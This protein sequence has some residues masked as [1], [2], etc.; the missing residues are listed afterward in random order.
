MRTQWKVLAGA[1]AC[2]L[3]TTAILSSGNVA[4]SAGSEFLQLTSA[5]LQAEVG[6]TGCTKNRPPVIDPYACII[7]ATTCAP[8]TYWCCFATPANEHSGCTAENENVPGST[9]YPTAWQPEPYDCVG[10][11]TVAPCECGWT[12]TCYAGDANDE[13]CGM[14]SGPLFGC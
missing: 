5:E 13:Q 14:K 6:T 2:C 12:G 7:G 9:G 10:D 8:A 1:F 11:D 3:M 4:E